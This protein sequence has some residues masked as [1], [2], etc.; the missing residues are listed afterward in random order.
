MQC[1]TNLVYLL[2]INPLQWYCAYSSIQLQ[3]VAC[4][5]WRSRNSPKI[6]MKS[7]VLRI[8]SCRPPHRPCPETTG[9][10]RSVDF[11]WF[12][13]QRES[14]QDTATTTSAIAVIKLWRVSL[15]RDWPSPN[16]YEVGDGSLKSLYE[17]ITFD[18][19]PTHWTSVPTRFVQLSVHY[20]PTVA[21]WQR[22]ERVS[23]HIFHRSL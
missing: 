2:S 9:I 10:D 21:T 5:F 17:T 18:F 23:V 20:L 12:Y 8:P 13:W 4:L 16:E 7:R 6:C 11:Y 3:C 19:W 14:P 15:Q 1:K 22:S